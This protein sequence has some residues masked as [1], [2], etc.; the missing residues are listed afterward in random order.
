MKLLQVD[1]SVLGENSI[2]RRLT[3]DITAGWLAV[4]PET[5]VA[6][7][8]FGLSVVLGLCGQ[9]NLAQAAF[10]GFGANAGGIGTSDNQIS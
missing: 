5:T 7:A 2:S 3:R 6:I 9:I 10:F 1:A 4:H 8:V